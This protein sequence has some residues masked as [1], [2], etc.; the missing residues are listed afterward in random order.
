MEQRE[1]ENVSEKTK[2][3]LNITVYSAPEIKVSMTPTNKD[4]E[5]AREIIERFEK[6]AHFHIP[7]KA[8]TLHGESRPNNILTSYIAQALQQARDEAVEETREKWHKAGFN[9]GL[10]EGARAA[11]K[12]PCYQILES[13]RKF[14]QGQGQRIA[15]AIRK[16]KGSHK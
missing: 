10:E 3:D 4:L 8:K 7:E 9:D 12:F 16:L 6:F 14:A 5:K 11:E 13:E 2:A 1:G 15:S